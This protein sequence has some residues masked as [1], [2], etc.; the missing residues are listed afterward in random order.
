MKKISL[1]LIAL[2]AVFSFV[3]CNSMRE[4][5]IKDEALTAVKTNDNYGVYYEIFVGSFSDSND[6]G[7]GDLQGLINRL[8]YLNDGNPDSGKSLGVDGLWLMPIMP[9]PSYHKY[10]VRDYENID[11][12]YGTVNDFEQLITEADA[13]DID[14]MIDLVLNHTSNQHPWFKAAKKAMEDGD[15][16][17]PYL[18]YY[19]LVTEDEMENGKTYYPFYGDYYYEG[20]F[21]SSMPELNMDSPA[22]R[23]EIL[24]IMQYWYDLGVKGFRLDAAKY[25][26]FGDDTK[27]IEFWNW[28]VSEAKKMRSDT[29]I[30]GEVWSGDY[31]IAPYYENFSNF[32]F[33]MSGQQGAVATVA[34]GMDDVN[35][36]VS[37]LD[38]YRN[39]IEGVNPNAILTPF[40]SNH[41]MNRV[42][43]YLNVEDYTMYSA[44]S[45]YILSSGNPFIY[46]GEEIGMKGSRGTSNTDANR[47]L[48]M[49]W[50]DKDT[51][52][53]PI[54]TSYSPNQQINGTVKQQLKDRESL[55][56]HYKK[57]I[58][59]RHANP[60]IARGEYTPLKFDGY[61]TFGGFLST[62]QSSTVGV[63]HNVGESEIT[64]DLSLYMNHDFSTVRGYAGEGNAT[65]SG[66]T[67]TISPHTSVV[68]K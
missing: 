21:S 5:S 7:L 11:P 48:A 58:M 56:N 8:D 33:G 24:N 31:L 40:I 20:N 6:D 44:A 46:Y 65:L 53:D 26:Y 63:F 35:W 4:Y 19:T 9:S 67:L 51:V 12:G 57:L 14:V 2:F 37:Y 1:I 38:R 34:N 13:R 52:K 15:M 66:Q 36:Y 18:D 64:I 60:E 61:Y 62:Y 28:F 59:L 29:Y 50:G 25:I 16:D 47:R 32:D 3:S 45:M 55:F 17:N 49:L 22:V 54:G 27:N 10:D 68:L 39:I 41:D 23:D 43:G 30:V 42:A